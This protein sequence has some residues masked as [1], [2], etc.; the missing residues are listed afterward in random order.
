MVDDLR[1]RLILRGM[2]IQV[3]D[4][5]YELIAREG[6]DTAMGARPLRRALQRLVEDP[7]S[8]EL[9]MGRWGEGDVILVDCVA[10]ELVFAPGEG[11]VPAPRESLSA[12]SRAGLALSAAGG[13]FGG[14]AAGSGQAAD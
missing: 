11:E 9:L 8:E 1:Q 3:T 13:S 2:S 6:T 4:A 7:L 12:G 5:A 10:G 14:S